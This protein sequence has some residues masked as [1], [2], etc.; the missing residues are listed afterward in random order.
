MSRWIEVRRTYSPPP[1]VSKMTAPGWWEADDLARLMN[2]VTVIEFE[3]SKG[4]KPPYF[5]E[6][7]GDHRVSEIERRTP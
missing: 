7:R 5:K 2:G 6:L 3:D 4:Q 1:P